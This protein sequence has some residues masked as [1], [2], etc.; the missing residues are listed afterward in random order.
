MTTSPVLIKP[1]RRQ[2]TP[3]FK[4]AVV[5]ACQHPGASVTLNVLAKIIN[6]Q[7]NLAPAL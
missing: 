1:P 3:D 6:Q 7:L 2:Y 4:A 5:A